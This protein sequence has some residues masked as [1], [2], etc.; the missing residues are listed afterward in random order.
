MTSFK[1]DG[2]ERNIMKHSNPAWPLFLEV[3]LLPRKTANRIVCSFCWAYPKASCPLNMVQNW[4]TMFSEVWV[5]D[6][7][8]W[9]LGLVPSVASKC[10]G[11]LMM[12]GRI[13]TVHCVKYTFFQRL[14]I[15]WQL[16]DKWFHRQV[17]PV[18]L[19]LH[20]RWIWQNIWTWF[21]AS[22]LNFVAFSCNFKY[23]T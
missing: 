14:K 1:L 17:R 3:P 12:A 11:W 7:K 13:F 6:I 15:D 2:I 23:D 21:K 16:I 8:V 20:D 22:D 5:V 9:V 18:P 19:T 10:H 4:V